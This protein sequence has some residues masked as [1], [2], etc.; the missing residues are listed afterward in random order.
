[1]QKG[2]RNF[3]K[4]LVPF[5]L[6]A[7]AVLAL[8][9]R[10]GDDW[11]YE[12][13]EADTAAADE[14]PQGSQARRRGPAARLALVAA[15]TSLFFAG[16]AFTAGAGDQMAK[17]LDGSAT[18]AEEIAAIAA[19]PEATAAEAAA[20]ETEAAA[21]APEAAPVALAVAPEVAAEVVP[22]TPESELAALEA[23]ETAAAADASLATELAPAAEP[24]A[25]VVPGHLAESGGTS[26]VAPSGVA[27]PKAP[28]RKPATAQAKTKAPA[29]TK[30]VVRR[31]AAAPAPAPELEHEQ[32]F[33]EP[34][35]WLNRA[36]PDPT[37][38]SARLTRAFAH[39]LVSISRRHG[40]DWAAVLGV[41]RAQGERGSA[42]ATASEL[43]TISARL[44]EQQAWRGALAL[45]G[46]TGFADSAAALADL[47]RA[48]G[49]EA[50]VTG[51]EASKR[52]LA[53]R[54][55][56]EEDV[57]IYGGGR[58]DIAAGRIDVRILVVLAYLKER[59]G[60][61]TASSLFSGHRRLSRPGVVSAH[62]YGH[63]VDIA[64]V[65][66]ISIAG[67][68][69]PGGI[70]E[71]AVRSLLLLPGEL[72]PQQVISLLGMGGPSFPMRDHG[73]HIHVGF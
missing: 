2:N 50:L 26:Q 44:A 30:W 19:A 24:S 25:D 38:P 56:A 45:S 57:W 21:P 40:A 41:L 23:A 27:E 28:A 20:A 52:R 49:I 3:L 51:F 68:Q 11:E 46:R 29:T 47:Y 1:M 18:P 63:A 66:D 32:G 43:D 73:D 4:A 16:A 64:A 7:V 61:I 35:V 53:T 10:D 58:E 34:T 71:A 22:A 31:A 8:V 60:S 17:L 62:T 69:Q 55:L 12:R 33:G 37:P 65:G 72:Q 36:L 67:H 14:I 42:P 9:R 39:R 54:L 5:G 59:H 48:V 6:L 15:F 70:T 13:A